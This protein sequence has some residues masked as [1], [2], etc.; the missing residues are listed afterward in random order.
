MGFIT[1]NIYNCGGQQSF[2]ARL[3]IQNLYRMS[4]YEYSISGNNVSEHRFS[5][6]LNLPKTKRRLI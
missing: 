6:V 1:Q 2:W 5:H 4:F 3:N